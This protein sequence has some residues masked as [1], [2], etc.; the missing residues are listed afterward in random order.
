MKKSIHVAEARCL[1]VNGASTPGRALL[2]ASGEKNPKFVLP[3]LTLRHFSSGGVQGVAT[4][5]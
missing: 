3:G 5:L 2:V 4:M 1:Q